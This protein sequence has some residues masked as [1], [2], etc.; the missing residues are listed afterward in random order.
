MFPNTKQ[1][2]R[3]NV[4]YAKKYVYI[5]KKNIIQNSEKKKLN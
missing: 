2:A 4:R 1:Y 5:L 3:T